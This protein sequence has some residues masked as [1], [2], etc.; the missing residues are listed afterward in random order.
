M[1]TQKILQSLTYIESKEEK[2]EREQV[3][4]NAVH[5]V[6]SLRKNWHTF[7]AVTDKELEIIKDN[8]NK[9]LQQYI[10]TL[11]ELNELYAD[12]IRLVFGNEYGMQGLIKHLYS[13]EEVGRVLM[14]TFREFAT[15]KGIQ[16]LETVKGK[17]SISDLDHEFSHVDLVTAIQIGSVDSNEIAKEQTRKVSEVTLVNR[18]EIERLELSKKH[19][20]E[21]EDLARKQNQER[22]AV[23]LEPLLEKDTTLVAT[24]YYSR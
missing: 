21:I 3:V 1:L 24:Y 2:Q 19:E 13:L 9:M 22:K 5:K 10:I 8:I 23:G 12:K 7:P 15:E 14:E 20:Q 11:K 17:Y 4:K 16:L 6:K 18:H